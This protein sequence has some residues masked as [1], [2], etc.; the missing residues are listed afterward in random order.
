[1]AISPAMPAM[2]QGGA[3]VQPGGGSGVT[4]NIYQQPG[5]DAEALAARIERILDRRSK[6]AARGSYVDTD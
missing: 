2:A 6:T 5:E 3:G 1:M 4:I